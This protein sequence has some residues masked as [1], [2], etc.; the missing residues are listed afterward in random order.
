MS[1]ED[2]ENLASDQDGFEDW[3]SDG[4]DA[5]KIGSG[6]IEVDKVGWYHVSLEAINKPEK[7]DPNDM[8]KQ[9]KPHVLIICRVLESVAG[10]SPKGAVYRHN[11]V[12]GGKGGG[13]PETYD[14]EMTLN[15]MTGLGICVV[16]DD[17]V[18]DP[19]G[20]VSADG[21]H[22]MNLKTFANRINGLKQAV[23]HLQLNKSKDEQYPDRIQL[24]YGRG[25]FRVDAEEVAHVPK[26][27]EALKAAG[28]ADVS[29]GEH[30]KASLPTSSNATVNGTKAPPATKVPTET[31]DDLL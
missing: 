8:T 23:L 3:G 12:V 31:I 30:P 17:K 10:Q 15:V 19:D 2:W 16:K 29:A 24:I 18:I 5:S 25:A 7:C 22:V 26:N 6:D 27:V 11:L 20:K 21:Q 13:M 9:R 14:K 1:N 28:F 4:V